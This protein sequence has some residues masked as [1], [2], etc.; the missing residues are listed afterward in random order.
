MTIL[1]DQIPSAL[2]HEPKHISDATTSEAG[3]VITPSS[4]TPGVSVLRHLT[5]G[6]VRARVVA[7]PDAALIEPDC[8]TTDVGVLVL[9]A[10]R[11]ISAPLGSPT[12]QQELSLLIQ[13][14]LTG[15]RVVT[16]DSAYQFSGS[17]PS[18]DLSPGAFAYYSFRWSSAAAKWVQ[19]VRPVGGGSYSGKTVKNNTTVIAVP[20]MTDAANFSTVADWRQV[21]GI[22]ESPDIA[23]S[24]GAI[25][26]TNDLT[27]LVT[28]VYQV[29]AWFSAAHSVNNSDIAVNFGVNGVVQVDRPVRTF[30]ATSGEN[31]LVVGHAYINLVAGQVVTAWVASESA[32]NI[33]VRQ[34]RFSIN[35]VERTA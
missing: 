32:G 17:V 1:H 15:N 25:R 19:Y 35:L 23:P 33:T 16:F 2:C 34:G 18:P 4:S 30:A 13:Q 31:Y 12:E 29:D 8:S 24:K 11:T 22:F 28:G 6:D 14:D 7:I 5:S 10:N 27:V 26:G 3:K 9:G 21:T 20:A